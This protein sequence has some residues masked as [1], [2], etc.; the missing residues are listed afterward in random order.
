[1]CGIAG[2]VGIKNKESAAQKIG[3]MLEIIKHRGPDD[4]GIEAWDE[5]ILAHRRLSILD[6]SAAGHQ[7]MLSADGEIGV[8]FNGAIYNFVPLRH[9][10]EA[11]GY[12]FKSHTDTE[13]LIHGYRAW[14]IDKLLENQ[15]E[16][17]PFGNQS[18]LVLHFLSEPLITH[19]N[20]TFYFNH[21]IVKKSSIFPNLTI[22]CTSNFVS[23]LKQPPQF[24]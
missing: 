13:V 16:K 7:P 2:I 22:F 4:E 17:S 18:K 10:L 9:E 19:Q 14:G 24:S 15:D 6:L 23:K 12:Q 3:A 11:R 20:P 5:A 1:M 8:V 21:F